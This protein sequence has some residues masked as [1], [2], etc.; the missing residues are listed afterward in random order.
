MPKSIIQT[1]L[2]DEQN[3]AVVCHNSN[4]CVGCVVFVCEVIE[5]QEIRG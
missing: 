3:P 2:E 5:R 1:L 4:R